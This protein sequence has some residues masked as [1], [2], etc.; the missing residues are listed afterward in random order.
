MQTAFLLLGLGILL[1]EIWWGWRMGVMRMLTSLVALVGSALIGMAAGR[2]VTAIVGGGAV[3]FWG[4]AVVALVLSY[5]AIWLFGYL[6][7]KKTSQ[8]PMGLAFIWGMGGA[9]L[10]F[11]FG[12]LV[13]W[14]MIPVVRSAGAMGDGMKQTLQAYH[15]PAPLVI[16]GLAALKEN[17]ET[18]ITGKIFSSVDIASPDFYDLLEKLSRLSTDPAC[19]VRLMEYP[20]LKAVAELPEIQAMAADPQIIAA[21]EDGKLMAVVTHPSLF[22]LAN[23]KKISEMVMKIDFR[24]ALDYA[25]GAEKGFTSP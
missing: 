14:L 2:V 5:I 7:F 8:Q 6:S 9:V 18:G 15:Q 3:V 4:V 11:V 1:F 13:L 20:D 23:D 12:I 10:G 21:I 22:K 25:V 24:K 17:L 19:F 16:S